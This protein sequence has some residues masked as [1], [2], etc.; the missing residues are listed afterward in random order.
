MGKTIVII[1]ESDAGSIKPVT[2]ELAALAQKLARGE[3]TSTRG[4][5]LGEEVGPAAHEMATTAGIDVT[6][7]QIPG[8]LGYNAE[9]YLEALIPLLADLDP[10]YVILAHTARGMDLAPALAIKLQAA[11]ISGVGNCRKLEGRLC[12]ARPLYNGKVVSW[13]RPLGPVAVVTVQPGAFKLPGEK[14]APGKVTLTV[15]PAA[16]AKTRYMGVRQSPVDTAGITEAS[17]IV[18]AGQGIGGEDNL[19][20]LYRL[21]EMF[22]RSAV[23]GSRIVCD[24]GWLDHR[25]QVGITGATVTAQL[26]IACGISGAVQHVAGM[27]GSEFIVAIN[28][29]PSAAIFQVA[30]VCIVEDLTTFIPVL[31]EVLKERKES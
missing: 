16:A 31:I 14:T 26:Y 20:L 19:E 1:A 2:Y 25:C 5:V 10:R 22:S 28:R 4:I 15:M 17:V 3:G 27:Q 21:A 13:I 18:A 6:G 12:F 9:Q 23:A 11:C 7:V 30:D 24:R 8:L 29:D